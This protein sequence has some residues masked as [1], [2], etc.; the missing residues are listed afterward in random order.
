METKA[1]NYAKA[2]N[3]IFT[4]RGIKASIRTATR[5]ARHLSLGVRLRNPLQLNDALNLANPIALETKTKAVIAQRRTDLPGL[6]SYQFQLDERYWQ[7]ITRADVTGCGVGLAESRRQIDFNFD[8]APHALVAGITGSGKTETVKS[9]LVG[10]CEVYTPDRMRIALVDPDYDYTS[11]D[12]L[13]HLA[14]PVAREGDQVDLALNWA[15]GELVGR[16]N[17]NEKDS[18]R[19]LVVIDEA[20]DTLKDPKRLAIAQAI[21]KGGRKFNVN[22]LVATQKP[23]QDV[24]PDLINQLGNRFV[25]KVDNAQMSVL[26][27]GHAGLQAHKLTLRGDFLHVNGTIDRLQ[28]AMPI[29][30]DFE[31][32]PRRDVVWPMFPEEDTPPVLNIESDRGAGRPPGE[33]DPRRLAAYL[34]YGPDKISISQA[35]KMLDLARYA[36]YAHRDF[37]REVKAELMRLMEV[38]R[39]S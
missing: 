17:R 24:L 1:R 33:L 38:K 25:G 36:H 4:Q 2:I 34:W 12:N 37:A 26:L 8:D 18:H 9:I 19:I 35:R 6:I 39:A 31:R 21:A 23:K 15:G 30:R 11:F 28:V 14:L 32:L 22:L 5:G 16:K 7:V 13:A 27:T 20:E 10:L 29:G 3:F